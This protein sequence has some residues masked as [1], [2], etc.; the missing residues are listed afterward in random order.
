MSAA[1]AMTPQQKS[2]LARLI[3]R[4]PKRRGELERAAEGSILDLYESYELASLA[5]IQWTQKTEPAAAAIADD[6][7]RIVI[8]LEQE[9]AAALAE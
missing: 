5:Y 6:Y 1:V 7:R 4:W 9:I 2:G 8:E 3:L